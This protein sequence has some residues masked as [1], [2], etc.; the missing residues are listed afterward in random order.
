MSQTCWRHS[1]SHI[2]SIRSS[3]RALPSV[4][5]PGNRA[6]GCPEE[7]PMRAGIALRVFT[8]DFNS[9]LQ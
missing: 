4:P 5:T 8:P 1:H 9:D 6:L 3:Y 2:T 7:A